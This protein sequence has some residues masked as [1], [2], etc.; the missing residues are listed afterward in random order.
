MTFEEPVARCTQCGGDHFAS[1]DVHDDFSD[2]QHPH[3][4]VSRRQWLLFG[5]TLIVLLGVAAAVLATRWAP[6]PPTRAAATPAAP[7]KSP[8]EQL[9]ER[10]Q[11]GATALGNGQ[12]ALALGHYQAAVALKGDDVAAL[13]GLG[14]SQVE[15]GRSRLAVEPLEKAHARAS[16]DADVLM[17]LGTAYLDVKRADD[18]KRLLGEFL[19]LYPKH[20][21]AASVRRDLGRAR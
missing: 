18:A 16:A 19:R 9:R 17:W 20:P 1:P 8:E 11:A 13:T 5:V 4:R 21:A 14:R 10:L 12:F 6:E 15:L 3:D 7:R 2:L